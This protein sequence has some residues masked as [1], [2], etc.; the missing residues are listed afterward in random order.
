MAEATVTVPDEIVQVIGGPPTEEQWRAISMPLEPSVIIAGAGSGK[1]SVMA[2]RVVYLALARVGLIEGVDP[3]QGVFP[4]N[5]LCLTFT[6]KATDNLRTKIRAAIAPLELR[7]GDEPEILNYHGFAARLIDRHGLLAGIEP[8]RRLMTPAQRTELC[9]QVLDEMTFEHAA[10]EWQPTL[11]GSI[12]DLADQAA[13]H[14]VTPEQIIRANEAEIPR[15]EKHKSSTAK[16]TALSRIEL[17][18]AV[19]RFL[20]LKRDRGL[21]DYGDQ[22]THALTIAEH[23]P[24]VVADYRARFET[25]LLDEYQDTNVA[26]AALMQALFGAGFPVTAVGDPDQNIY[27]WRGAS[28]YNLVRFAEQF[29][30]ADGSPATVL[31][32]ATNFRSGRRILVAADEVIGKV[33]AS[34]RGA[35]DKRLIA[36]ED[37]GEGE[38]V[39]S[40]FADEW[41]EARWI[42]SQIK[43]LHGESDGAVPWSEFAVLCRK[44][45]LF[46]PLQA[47]FAEAGIPAEFVGLAGLL[48]LPEIVEVLSYARAVADPMASPSHARILLGPR[49]RIGPADLSQVAGWAVRRTRDWQRAQL[50]EDEITRFSLEEALEHLDEIEHVS[51]DARARLIE[52]REELAE[53][54]RQARRPVGEFLAEVI[55]RIGLL[56]ELDA[57]PAADAER[58]AAAKRNLAAFLDEVHAFSPVDGELT[59]RSFLDYV[60]VL[61]EADREEWEPVQPSS[62]DSV[63][64]LTIHK[65]KGLE[66]EHVFVPGV[67]DRLLPDAIVQQNPAEKPKS[68]N[69]ELR[70]DHEIL[71]AYAGNLKD[72]WRSLRDQALIEERRTAYVA[73]TRAKQGLYVTAAHWYGD[74]TQ[75]PRKRSAFFDELATW[76][77][78]SSLAAVTR[79]PEV[80]EQNPIHGY[81]D[82]LARPWPGP[83]RPDDSD[84]TFAAGWRHAAADAAAEGGVQSELLDAL[85][86]DDRAAYD[87]AAT[88][89]R[90][91][92]GHIREREGA[93][94]QDDGALVPSS[95]ASTGVIEYLRCPKR[96][97]WQRIR[98]LPRFSGPAA[99]IG[100]EVHAW[101]EKRSAGQASLLPEPGEAAA[102]ATEELAGEPGK[103][104]RLHRAFLESRFAALTPL[105]A[106]RAFLLRVDDATVNGRIDAIYGTPDGPWEIVDYKT[107]RAPSDEDALVWLQLDLYALACV[108]VWGKRPEELTLTYLYL[109]DGT[110]VE[111]T[112]AADDV[113]TTRTRVRDALTGI[114]DGAFDPMPGPACRYCD[115]R[116]FCEPGRA[117]LAADRDA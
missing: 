43:K 81:R 14:R 10:A 109:G 25:V 11:I 46:G 40:R 82:H 117:W 31:P 16:E 101:I 63:K 6:N 41:D 68:L 70:G 103:V 66:F 86:S 76:G 107:G 72:F 75:F 87:R 62:E 79:G 49:Y 57:A 114:G 83:A 54:R 110:P 34:Q 59:L 60:A 105:Y 77:E 29:P 96:F 98:P 33:P 15:F 52:Y 115:F 71:P 48:K 78:G 28:L 1:T 94:A 24:D 106:E 84:G 51:A 12:L 88:E 116:S 97:Y 27:A 8:G 111:R 19:R 17:A 44:S 38:V 4:G 91:L 56:T 20:D 50:D 37:N 73:L 100:T 112:R 39:V 99:R 36:W 67:A 108:E 61:D 74:N 26:Q 35:E 9:A 53:L 65:A 58:A 47:A 45:R 89:R 95:F 30:R 23:H 64:V 18:H 13:D 22:I 55:R 80:D 85:S 102:R 2:A 113:E 90:E 69:F 104:E 5:V 42:A 3:E 92:A 21:Y 93:E 32:L 7:E